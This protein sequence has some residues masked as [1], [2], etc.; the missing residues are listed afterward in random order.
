MKIAF[1]EIVDWEANYIKEKLPNHE[2]SFYSSTFSDDV[3]PEAGVDIISTFTSS[4]VTS[5]VL[6]A[7]PTL[8][9]VATRTTGFDHIHID[10]CLARGVVAS[11]VPT[12]GENTVAE[13]TFALLLM[14]SRKMYPA[15]KRIREQAWFNFENLRG[16]DLK[17][18]TMGVIGTGHIGTYVVK[19]ARGFGMNVVA[20]DPFP[21]EKLAKEFEFKYLSLSDLLSQSDVITLHVPYM[22]STHH[23]INKDNIKLIKPGSVLVNTARGGLVETEAM[24]M[25]L[26]SGIL[27]GAALDVLEE[28]GFIKDEVSMLTDGHPQEQQ[29]KTVLAD[30]ELMHMD[31]VIITPHNAFQT[32]E[33]IKRI[34][35]TTVANIQAFIDGKPINVITKEKK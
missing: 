28:E 30:H 16:F 12:Y 9:F 34:L 13:F 6:E 21:N 31:N 15:V 5:K 3:L 10:D 22:P 26:R 14:L 18:K 17:D 2:L 20:Y 7:V 19:I 24:V 29:M 32:T 35:D 8:K 1:Y 23:L 27:A 33:A 11:N 4:P 25:A